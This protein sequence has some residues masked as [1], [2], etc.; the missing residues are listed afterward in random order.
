[1]TPR[2]YASPEAFKRALEER[3]RSSASTGAEFARARQLLV[4]DRFLA[5]I[6]AV[7][8]DAATLKGGLA[9]ELRLERFASHDEAEAELLD[10]IE[11]FYNQQRS[12]STLDYV[13]PAEFERNARQALQAVV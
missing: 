13:S 9:L 3:L 7:Y 8:G 10:Y 6:V 5:R 1:M 12:H 4:F 11:V 2:T